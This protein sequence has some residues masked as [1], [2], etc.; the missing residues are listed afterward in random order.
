MHCIV[1]PQGLWHNLCHTRVYQASLY[2][3]PVPHHHHID[4]VVLPITHWYWW[5]RQPSPLWNP[6]SGSDVTQWSLGQGKP[7][8]A[9]DRFCWPWPDQC[10]VWHHNYDGIGHMQ[11]PACCL[12]WSSLDRVPDPLCMGTPMGLPQE[13]WRGTCPAPAPHVAACGNLSC[14]S[15][16]HSLPRTTETH[17]LP[18]TLSSI[19]SCHCTAG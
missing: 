10:S 3:L 12:A 14:R 13:V 2:F 18:P 15:S 11:V 7:T 16:K 17:S 19:S 1:L 4:I 5:H 8:L 6:A 9:V